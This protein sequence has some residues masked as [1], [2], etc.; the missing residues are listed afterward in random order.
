MSALLMIF[1]N[2]LLNPLDPQA[3]QDLELLECVPE[4]IKGLKIRHM[5]INE[6]LHIKMVDDFVAELTRLAK[7]AIIKV[8]KESGR[9]SNEDL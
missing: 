8:R 9:I 7:C 1:C 5:T 2:L 6:I 4:V 3:I